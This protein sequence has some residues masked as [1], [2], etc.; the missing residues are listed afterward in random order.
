MSL[1]TQRGTVMADKRFSL[2]LAQDVY[3]M[4]ET[5]AD[6]DDRSINKMINILL[7]EAC[8]ARNKALDDGLF[9]TPETG[10]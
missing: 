2:R 8:N 5:W 6:A 10:K 3:H 4:V 9:P 1:Q 7:S